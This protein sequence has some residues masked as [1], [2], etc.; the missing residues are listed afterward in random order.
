MARRKKAAYRRKKQNKFAI[1]LVTAVLLM[2][3]V[4]VGYKSRE[5][6]ETSKAYAKQEGELQSKI[7]SEKERSVDLEEY[8]KLTQTRGFKEEYA[9]ENLNLVHDDQILFQIGDD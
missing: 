7:D 5:L 9:E 6:Q 2:L 1:F 8:E 3:V 4:A